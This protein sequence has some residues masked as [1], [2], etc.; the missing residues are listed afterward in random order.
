MAKY[1]VDGSLSEQSIQETVVQYLTV[2]GFRR[3]IIFIPNEG[4]RTL[5]YGTKL[6]K[7]GLRKG[8]SDLFIAV[9]RKDFH[10]MFLE[11]KS[12]N[13]KLRPSQREFLA[14]MEEQKYF[15]AVCYS[16]DSAIEMIDFY[17]FDKN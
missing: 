15:T 11:L 4:A 10:G 2:K 13:G 17:L 16:I 12:A 3:Y 5:S 14:D 9:A 8:A 1:N 7:M 6:G